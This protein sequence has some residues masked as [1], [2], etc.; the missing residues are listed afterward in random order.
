MA[1]LTAQKKCLSSENLQARYHDRKPLTSIPTFQ[2]E[3]FYLSSTIAK[4]PQIAC[5]KVL[6]S[7]TVLPRTH[8]VCSCFL[9]ENVTTRSPKWPAFFLTTRQKPQQ[10]HRS[11]RLFC[12][13]A[14]LRPLRV[15]FTL[16][17]RE[18][19]VE[20]TFR[21]VS[22]IRGLKLRGFVHQ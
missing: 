13:R 18:L 20:P 12:T 5:E 2:A 1:T 11:N 22:I 6:T 14:F 4:V 21:Q 8:Y 7:K 15:S 17:P 9:T 16:S 19:R 10:K 3:V